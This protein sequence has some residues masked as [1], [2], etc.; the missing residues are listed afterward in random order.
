MYKALALVVALGSVA[1]AQKHAKRAAPK[2]VKAVVHE[3]V[4]YVASHRL[5]AAGTSSADSG[6]V[7]AWDVK[8]KKKL[9]EAK[10]YEST[11]DPAKEQDVQ[12]VFITSMKVEG[13][14][15]VVTNERKETFEIDLASHEVNQR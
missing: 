3:G 12:N 1:F 7:E 14:K 2:D 9:W 5:T 6:Y 8:K 15:L 4:R 10:L 13:A 11:H